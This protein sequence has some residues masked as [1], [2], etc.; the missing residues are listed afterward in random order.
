[1]KVMQSL[2]G[3]PVALSGKVVG[4]LP[5]T[6][7][8]QHIDAL[9]VQENSIS[10][11]KPMLSNSSLLHWGEQ[12]GTGFHKVFSA[13][14]SIARTIVHVVEA[15]VWQCSVSTHSN[16]SILRFIKSENA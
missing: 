3:M 16:K 15:N 12:L 1:M 14:S 7:T 4:I 6:P 10:C 5:I 9:L 2:K 8:L 11:G 13:S